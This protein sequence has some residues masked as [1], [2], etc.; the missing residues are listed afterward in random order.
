M[1]SGPQGWARDREAWDSLYC[2]D[3]RSCYSIERRYECRAQ[4]Q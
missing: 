3:E 1:S 2:G 4:V